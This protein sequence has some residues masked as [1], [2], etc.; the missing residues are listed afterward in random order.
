[1]S[2][3]NVIGI[4]SGTSLDGVDLAHCTFEMQDKK[5]TYYVNNCETIAYSYEWLTRL[6]TLHLGSA[7]EYAETHTM[8]GRYLGE[9]VKTFVNKHQLATDFVSSHG[10]TI[11]HKPAQH[12]TS[13]IGEG[14]AIAAISGLP[15]ICDFRTG[16]VAHGGQGAPLVPIGDELLFGEFD[17]CLNLG[18]FANIS[19]NK[20]KTRIA[21]DIAPANIILNKI[22]NRF[23]MPYDKGGKIASSGKIDTQLLETLNNISFYKLKPPK[24][25][26]REWLEE[27]MMPIIELCNLSNEDIACT[28]CEHIGMQIGTVVD[29]DTSQKILITGGGA[30]NTFLLGRI[31][32]HTKAQIVLPE[33]GII[34]FKEALVF[35]FLGVLRWDQKNNCLST[36]TGAKKDN[37]GGALYLP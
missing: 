5:L 20:N 24:S 28:L 26:G 2:K 10:H 15:V 32:A 21:F 1:M 23:G 30:F 33:A 18:G 25:L 7:L 31:K 17:Y 16:D 37:C 27:T 8:Y 4:M 29:E 34:N 14:A 22:A 6:R 12:Y 19:F 11:F 36:V 13:Q 9:L 3:Y 35:A